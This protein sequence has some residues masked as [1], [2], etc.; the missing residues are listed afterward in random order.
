MTVLQDYSLATPTHTT[1][2]QQRPSVAERLTQILDV[3]TTAPGR[4]SL[5]DV[6]RATG[7]PRSTAFRILTQLVDLHWVEHDSLGYGPGL[8]I[9]QMARTSD[10]S[11]LRSIASPALNSLHARTGGVAHLTVLEGSSVYFL[12]R[13]GGAASASVP[14]PVATRLPADSTVS[15][16]VLLAGLEPEKVDALMTIGPHFRSRT[17]LAELHA[18][19]N[20]IRGSHGLEFVPGDRCEQSIS[21]VAAPIFGPDGITGAI[22]LACP[23]PVE[24]ANVAPLVWSAA[25]RTA[26][27]LDSE[28]RRRPTASVFLPQHS[29]THAIEN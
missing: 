15:G 5:E 3:V 6:S 28:R 29:G 2:D 4:V 18:R 13:I 1:R 8:R 20:R 19:L 21:A 14:S 26:G 17:A 22:S 9:G 12:D 25:R 23:G 11:R 24:L 16:R 7:L 27:K 10:Y